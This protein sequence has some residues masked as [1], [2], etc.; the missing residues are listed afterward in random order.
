MRTFEE[1]KIM[2][3]ANKLGRGFVA[4][5]HYAVISPP[6]SKLSLGLFH[7]DKLVGVAIWGYGT[8]P[9]HT[10]KKI[11]PPLEV[12]NYLELNRLCV[13]DSMPR[14]TESRFLSMMF[15]Y[16]KDNF[17][18]VKVLYSWADGLRGKPGYVYQ[19]SSFLYGGFIWSQFY[20]TKD[21]EVI[22][23]RFLITRYGTRAK[24][25]TQKLGLMKI[26]GYQYRY[27]RFVCSHRERKALLRLSP[28]EWTQ[29]YPKKKDLKWV[30]DAEEGSRESRE[31][32]KLKGPVR[33][34]HSAPTIK[35]GKKH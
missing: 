23:P 33:F 35:S 11:F 5:H 28:M 21:G 9:K 34:R 25:L 26:K 8:R 14:N 2:P 17:P 6:I 10:I 3:I 20:A 4:Q 13:L 22:H 29:A 19:A 27:C 32:P 12:E 30:I 24:K 18:L 16:I 7:R 31:L 1:L 15:G